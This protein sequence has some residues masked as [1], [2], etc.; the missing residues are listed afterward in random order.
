MRIVKAIAYAVA[1]TVAYTVA[2]VALWGFALPITILICWLVYALGFHQTATALGIF[3]ACGFLLWLAI[4]ALVCH[5]A[6][7]NLGKGPKINYSY[8]LLSAVKNHTEYGDTFLG[9]RRLGLEPFCFVVEG[10]E[11]L[12]VDFGVGDVICAGV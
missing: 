11:G 7:K 9:W 6:E 4:G 12:I 5:Y 8:R 1:C 3:T 10:L 2:A